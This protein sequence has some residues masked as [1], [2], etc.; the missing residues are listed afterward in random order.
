VFD[1]DVSGMSVI[2]HVAAMINTN[3]AAQRSALAVRARLRA[4]EE[5]SVIADQSHSTTKALFS[6]NWH[7]QQ[8]FQVIR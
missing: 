2:H 7:Q 8:W 1:Q 5:V 3:I 6:A 4:I